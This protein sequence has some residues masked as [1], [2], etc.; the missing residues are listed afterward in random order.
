MMRFMGD[1]PPGQPPGSKWRIA[2]ALAGLIAVTGAAGAVVAILQRP[3]TSSPPGPTPTATP[4]PFPSFPQ[5][6]VPSG[7]VL[8]FG[9]SAVDDPAAHQVLV[10]GGVD[11]YDSTWLWNGTRWS[12]ARP[13]VSPA[14]RFG[15]AAAYDPATQAVMLF[16]GRLAPGQIE[17][18]T[19]SW[20]G[21]TWRELNNGTGGPPA[22]EG[23]LMAWDDA[24][25]QMVLV[26]SFASD[27]SKTWVWAGNHWV[28]RPSRD[29]PAGAF[30]SGMAFDPAT[31]TLLFVSATPPNGAGTSTWL[32]DA[33][34][35][36]EGRANIT[37]APC[38][39][40]LDPVREQLLL[41]GTT[42]GAPGPQ[43][44]SWSGVSWVPIQNSRLPIEPEAE[45]SDINRGQ[46]LILGSLTQPSQ[47][48]PQPLELWSWNGVAWLR[49]D[50]GAG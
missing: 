5:T 3:S 6:P 20:N 50:A 13:A 8:G 11:S 19:W 14:G 47:G 29:L 36:R 49:V 33:T 37:A 44:W 34:G 1:E 22:G 45:I 23:A 35:W 40:A 38:G 41:C 25:R 18:D 42:P 4:F 17:N 46:I 24:T 9:F 28:S 10:F 12:L 21:S 32:W 26:T 7:P 48:F 31:D 27:A 43:V 15:A 2:A 39:V 16:G 30:G